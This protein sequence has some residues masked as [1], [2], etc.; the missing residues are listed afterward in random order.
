MNKEEF[1]EVIQKIGTCE[2]EEDRRAMLTELQDKMSVVYDEIENN[3]TTMDALNSTI[4]TKDEE[5]SKL[6][7]VNMDYFMRISSQKSEQELVKD[8]TGI[9]EESTKTR[10]Y[11]DLFDE[12]G[13]IK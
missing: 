13:M 3:K 1:I 9:N 5:I 8:S 4:S 6:Q 7:K 12:K 10:R 2:A 11:E